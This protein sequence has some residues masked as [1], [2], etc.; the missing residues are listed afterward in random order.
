MSNGHESY[1]TFTSQIPTLYELFNEVKFEALTYTLYHFVI[2][3][4]ITV[5]WFLQLVV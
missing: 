1:N 5:L 2:A 4:V 3:L